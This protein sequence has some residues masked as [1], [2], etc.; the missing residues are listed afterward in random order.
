MAPVAFGQASP[1]LFS[2]RCLRRWC[3]MA[4]SVGWRTEWNTNRATPSSG[5]RP[6]AGLQVDVWP[7]DGHRFSWP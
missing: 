1:I 6:T 7:T 5:G 2:A 3:G 4:A